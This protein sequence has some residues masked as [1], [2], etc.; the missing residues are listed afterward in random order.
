[1]TP[2]YWIAALLSLPLAVVWIVVAL[3]IAAVMDARERL[4]RHL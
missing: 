4:E 1:M 3:F 2:L